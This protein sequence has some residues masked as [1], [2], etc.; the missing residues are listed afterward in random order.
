MDSQ[1]RVA[2]SQ[3]A[4]A[5]AAAIGTIL[6]LPDFA[7]LTVI[8]VLLGGLLTILIA[9]IA[10]LGVTT[11]FGLITLIPTASMMVMFSLGAEIAML[12]SVIGLVGAGV[13]RLLRMVQHGA[14]DPFRGDTLV[15]IGNLLWPIDRTVLSLLAA[16]GMFYLLGG[17]TPLRQITVLPTDLFI[18]AVTLLVFV[19]IYN[20][21]LA[22]ELALKG[23]P[24]VETFREHQVTIL[25]I[26]I[27]PLPLAPLAAVSLG[28]LGWGAFS[29]FMLLVFATSVAI[30][31]L[32]KTQGSLQHQVKQLRS[33]TAMTQAVRASLEVDSLLEIAYIQTKNL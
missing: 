30:N 10:N 31:E 13:I 8:E 23:V 7:Q 27:L 33:L 28:E 26:Q 21:F 32:V 24:V 20:V 11:G 15:L 17:Q 29:I 4:L 1:Q 25:G 22:A 14:K 19:A 9:V 16:T 5:I 18:I 2:I 12:S 3:I 6:L